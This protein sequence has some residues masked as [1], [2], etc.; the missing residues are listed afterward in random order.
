VNTR[1]VAYVDGFNLY[2]G[3]HTAT[4]RRDLWLNLESLS[5]R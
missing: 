3:L 2:N 4:G 1:I 5:A